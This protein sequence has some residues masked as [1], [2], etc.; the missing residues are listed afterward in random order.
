MTYNVTV[1]VSNRY[2][3]PLNYRICNHETQLESLG[4]E[5][6]QSLINEM[7]TGGKL[8]I[9]TIINIIVTMLLATMATSGGQNSSL[10]IIIPT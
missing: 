6:Q 1:S 7:I 9:Q 4:T 8:M 3:L 10:N 5:I 2:L